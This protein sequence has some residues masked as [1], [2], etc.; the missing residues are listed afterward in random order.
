MPEIIIDREEFQGDYDIKMLHLILHLD[1]YG[2]SWDF[3]D[4]QT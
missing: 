2:Y 4:E 3:K 1:K